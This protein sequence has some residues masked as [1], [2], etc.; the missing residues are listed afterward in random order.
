MTCSPTKQNPSGCIG[1]HGFP[2]PQQAVSVMNKMA[3]KSRVA[4][5]HYKC[6]ACGLWHIGTKHFIKTRSDR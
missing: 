1:K 3:N 4:L 6:P 5:A 2:T